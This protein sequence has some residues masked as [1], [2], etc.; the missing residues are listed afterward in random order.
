MKQFY[1]LMKK[2]R[3]SYQ[4]SNAIAL[5]LLFLFPFITQAADIKLEAENATLNGV[6]T[7]TEYQGYSGASYAWGFDNATDN[8]TFTFQAPSAGL[9]ELS[10]IFVSPYGDKKTTLQVNGQTSEQDFRNTNGSFSTLL[11]GK[12]PLNAGQNTISFTHNWGYYGIDYILLK[13]ASDDPIV[14][15]PLENGRAEAEKGVFDGVQATSSPAG[16]SGNAYVTSFDNATDKVTI[17]FNATGGLYNLQIGYTSPF[18]PKGYDL[19]VN[20]E[21]GSGMFEGTSTENPFGIASAGKFYIKEGLNTVTILR[22]WG[23]FGIDYIQLTPTSVALPARPPKILSNEKATQATRSLFSY[24]VDL[25]GSKVLS[26]QQEN[27]ELTEISYIKTISGKEVAVGSFD[28]MEYSPSRIQFGANPN[29][30]AEKA[31]AWAQKDEG[32]GI[33][34]LLWHWNAPTDLINEAPDKLWWS[35]FYTRATTFDFAA[36]LADKTSERYNLMIRDIDAIAVQLKK[37]QEADIPV[38]WRPLHEASGGWFWWGAKGAAPFKELWRILYDR[39]TNHHQIHNLIW[40]YTAQIGETDWYP[41]DDVVDMVSTDI[42]ESGRTASS[43]SAQWTELQTKYGGRKMVALSETGNLPNP[44]FIRAYATWWSYFAAWTGN[45][46]IRGQ[47]PELINRVFND[48]DVITRDELPDWKMY[49]RP[50]V[51]IT[52]PAA[53]AQYLVCQTPAITA[54]ASDAEGSVTKVTFYAN[55][56]VI[57]VDDMPANGFSLEWKDAAAGT[58]A[59]VAEALDNEGNTNRSA[60]VSVSINADTEAPAITLSA[61][62]TVLKAEDHLLKTFLLSNI[63]RSVTD[64]CAVRVVRIKQVSSDEAAD[65]KG[66]GNTAQDIIISADGQSVQ[67]RAE[68][69]GNGN[70]RVYTVQIE[71]IDAYGNTGLATYRVEVPKSAGKNAIA[72]APAYWVYGNYASAGR[73]ATDNKI[74]VNEEAEEKEARDIKEINIYPN[75]VT[76]DEITLSIYSEREQHAQLTLLTTQSQVV[77]GQQQALKKGT[78]LVRFPIA[79]VGRGIYFLRITKDHKQ[80]TQ[81]VIVAK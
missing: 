49:G 24:L 71:A 55:N 69:S 37:F 30:Y 13:P 17:H 19:V 73:M 48:P 72:D 70:G 46:Y 4:R 9:Y 14:P 68:R 18:G 74:P 26:G 23:Y 7:A 53:N 6:G 15:V 61:A 64:N 65:A 41:G 47:A 56:V 35:G 80:Y 2:A 67:L 62:N 32:R 27:N 16:A 58:Y 51:S 34:S 44:D 25:Y 33:V 1:P 54:Q 40:V 78:N 45:D 75:P 22:G 10:V 60:P 8:V 81:K 42:Y 50:T 20:S 76:A 29:N 3:S 77:A 63:V 59:V 12:V 11:V 79:K 38:I 52:T 31:I 36:A 5:F 21:T 39:L 43:M 28:L 66:S 57:G